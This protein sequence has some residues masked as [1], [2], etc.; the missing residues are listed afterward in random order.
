MQVSGY[1]SGA[2][3]DINHVAAQVKVVH[4]RDHASIRRPHRRALGA[5][6]VDPHVTALN[7]A[8]ELAAIAE[9]A[10]HPPGSWV[11]EGTVPELLRLMRPATDLK[12]AF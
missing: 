1:Q 9:A 5:R 2:M 8:V 11:Y 3:I 12:G 10:R 6:K 4:E 7:D